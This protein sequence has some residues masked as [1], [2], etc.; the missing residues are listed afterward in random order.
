MN[1]VNILDKIEEVDN[2]VL[3]DRLNPRRAAMKEMFNF[4]KKAA[5]AAIPLGLGSM[6]NKASAQTGASD[7]VVAALQFVLALKHFESSLLTQGLAKVNFNAKNAA[8]DKVAL[9]QIKDQQTK[10]IAAL[11]QAITLAGKVPVVAKTYDFTGSGTYTDI[12]S[13]NKTF[14]RVFQGIKDTVIRATKGQ[15]PTLF[16]TGAY[17]EAALAIHAVDARHSAK[18]RLIRLFD[19]Y[20][21]A[22]KPWLSELDQT[23]NENIGK[24]VFAGEDNVTQASFDVTALTG[25]AVTHAQATEA[26]DEPLTM[27]AVLSALAPFKFTV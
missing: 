4:G 8:T 15:A 21:N 22:N 10:H 1:I 25:S 3:I 18:L 16:G 20:S 5:V 11:T 23:E 14:L 9:N 2:D 24:D 27:Q 12:F 26:F 7:T 13:S 19:G 17:L 6:F